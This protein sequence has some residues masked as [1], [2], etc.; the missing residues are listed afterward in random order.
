MDDTFKIPGLNWDNLTILETQQKHN[1][2][3]QELSRYKS[4]IK[5]LARL[6]LQKITPCPP[7]Q[8]NPHDP[9]AT[10]KMLKVEWNNK[11]VSQQN[12]HYNNPAQKNF[13]QGGFSAV[14]FSKLTRKLG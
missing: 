7:M 2:V 11:D 8:F 13:S 12:G 9:C 10:V 14:T 3:I 6:I 1:Y 4:K 5:Y